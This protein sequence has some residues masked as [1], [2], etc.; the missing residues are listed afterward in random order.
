M[1]GYAINIERACR[2]APE[3][4]DH[5]LG[6]RH[7]FSFDRA[8]HHRGGCLAYRA[9]F[10]F[11][12]D[13]LDLVIQHVHRQL[14]VIPTQRVVPLGMPVRTK[15]RT[16]VPRLAVV[17]EYHFLI[18]LPHVGHENISCTFR[19]PSTSLSISSLVL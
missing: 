5:G 13:S 6:I 19:M 8:R 11:K 15:Y 18:K 14:D 12:S 9:A 3:F 17:I 1:I 2:H 4:L 7:R 10:S 16:E